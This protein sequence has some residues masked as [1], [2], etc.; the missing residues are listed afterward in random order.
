[1][2]DVFNLSS[3]NSMLDQCNKKYAEITHAVMNY[4][5]HLVFVDIILKPVHHRLKAKPV[6]CYM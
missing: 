4:F 6:Y 1:M 5:N 2:I 3:A